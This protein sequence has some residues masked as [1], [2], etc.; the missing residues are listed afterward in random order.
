MHCA[1]LLTRG[2]YARAE[3]LCTANPILRYNRRYRCR[4]LR[5]HNASES[6][7]RA[8]HKVHAACARH[9]FA[10]HKAAL[11]A[12]AALSHAQLTAPANSGA[13][14]AELRAMHRDELGQRG[15]RGRL[16]ALR[17]CEH[18]RHLCQVPGVHERRRQVPQHLRAKLLAR[19]HA[20]ADDLASAAIASIFVK[21]R[22]CTSTAERSPSTFA[23]KCWLGCMQLRLT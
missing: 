20:N 9:A 7:V 4:K 22:G 21:S 19:L 6:E 10:T 23:R 15:P 5:T 14:Q 8:T 12:A 3:K 16:P 2:Y 1:I 17:V 11:T 18:R 13:N